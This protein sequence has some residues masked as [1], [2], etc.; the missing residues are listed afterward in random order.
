MLLQ[1]LRKSPRMKKQ[2][3]HL[4][5]LGIN[6]DDTVI[7][8][9]DDYHFQEKEQLI[10]LFNDIAPNWRTE[11]I[12]SSCGAGYSGTVAMLALAELGVSSS[13]FDE[14]FS[15]WKLDSTRPIEQ[16]Y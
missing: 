8:Y 1:I 9:D 11:K 5:N 12:I 10:S 13:L 7:L 15:V 16:S 4:K 14:S 3:N 6:K 2:N